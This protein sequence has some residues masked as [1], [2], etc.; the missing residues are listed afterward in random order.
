MRKTDIP[1]GLLAAGL[2]MF[3]DHYHLPCGSFDAFTTTTCIRIKNWP[4]V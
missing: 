3:T 4:A 2:F 1:G